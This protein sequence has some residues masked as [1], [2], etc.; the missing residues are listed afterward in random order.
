MG[1][2][3]RKPTSNES[4]VSIPKGNQWG[5]VD[6]F[7]HLID[8]T[9]IRCCHCQCVISKKHVTI[10]D[11]HAFCPDHKKPGCKTEDNRHHFNVTEF[12]EH[13]NLS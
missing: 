7:F 13:N 2:L 11:D 12:I 1:H 8:K 9:A 4:E 6:D 3:S 5:T 10:V